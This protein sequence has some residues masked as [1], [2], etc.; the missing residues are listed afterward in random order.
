MPEA[1]TEAIRISG[2]D[3]TGLRETENPGSDGI[4]CHSGLPSA[5]K[6]G[7]VRPALARIGLRHSLQSRNSAVD[8]AFLTFPAWTEPC[9]TDVPPGQA[10]SEYRIHVI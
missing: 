1:S 2:A 10:S 5:R 3:Y 7:I 8:G 4:R 6:S 9:G